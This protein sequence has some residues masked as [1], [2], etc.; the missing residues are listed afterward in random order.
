MTDREDGQAE[1]V[2]EAESVVDR[3]IR[4][5]AELSPAALPPFPSD[6]RWGAGRWILVA[7]AGLAAQGRLWL[8]DCGS[9]RVSISLRSGPADSGCMLPFETW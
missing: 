4:A 3:N 5:T 1:V 8:C 7:W 6:R 9:V 2:H